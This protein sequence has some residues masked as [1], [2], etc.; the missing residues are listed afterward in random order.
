MKISAILQALRTDVEPW[1]AAEGAGVI[2]A[3]DPFDPFQIVTAGGAGLV[4]VL[5]YAGTQRSESSRERPLGR[6]QFEIVLASRMSLPV[7]RSAGIYTAAGDRPPLV[8]ML[9]DLIQVVANIAIAD[10]TTSHKFEYAG[11]APLTA[12]DGQRLAAFVLTFHLTR[13]VHV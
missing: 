5:S 3:R 11:D 13:I 12:P 4:A 8:D 1:A 6:M 2:V 7:D 9:D 10:A